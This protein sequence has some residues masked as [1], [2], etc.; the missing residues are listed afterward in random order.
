MFSIKRTY[1]FSAAHRIEGH[2][3]CGRLHG[4]NYRV[5]V[6]MSGADIPKDGML[7]DFGELDKAVKPII[8]GHYDHRYLV[9]GSNLAMGDPYE[10]ASRGDR[11][12]DVL[13]LSTWTSTAEDLARALFDQLSGILNSEFR[14]IQSVSVEETD[15]NEAT[16]ERR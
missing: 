6:E 14:W 16:Y 3:K 9:S 10:K 5:T 15:R 1:S 11:T 12:G 13:Y 7:L 8:D 2:P 4:H